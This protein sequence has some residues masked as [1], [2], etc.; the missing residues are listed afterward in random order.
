[1]EDCR[2]GMFGVSP[3]LFH[4]NIPVATLLFK[5]RISP[6][7]P[8][9]AFGRPLCPRR[10]F[11]KRP[12][13]APRTRAATSAD[14]LVQ[15]GATAASNLNHRQLRSVGLGPRT[16]AEFLSACVQFRAR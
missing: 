16:T 4:M 7:S 14:G 2:P 11:G 13:P 8:F 12:P 15:D 1:M 6:F 10:A 9:L 3:P 5:S